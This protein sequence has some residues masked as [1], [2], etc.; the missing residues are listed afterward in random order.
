MTAHQVATFLL[1]IPD[2][3]LKIVVTPSKFIDG[4]HYNFHDIT[5]VAEVSKV[6]PQTKGEEDVIIVVAENTRKI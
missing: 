1:S 2:A 6:N 3:P 5:L 4:G